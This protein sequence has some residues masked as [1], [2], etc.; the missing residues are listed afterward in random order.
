MNLVCTY[1]K[2]HKLPVTSTWPDRK[3]ISCDKSHECVV[4]LEKYGI[5]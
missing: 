5:I 1:I 4:I 3:T 2:Q